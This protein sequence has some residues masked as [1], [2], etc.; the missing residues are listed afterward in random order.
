MR[1]S[2]RAT[3]GSPAEK[4]DFEKVVVGVDPT[5][6]ASGD[7]CGI[8]VVGRRRRADGESEA[9]VLADRSARGLSP[10]GWARRARVAAEAWGAASIVAEV[11]Q[12]GEMVKAVFR[13][14]GCEVPVKEVRAAVG[15]RARAEPV[16]ALYERGRVKHA[17]VFTELEE[18]LAAIGDED[19]GGLS[20]DRADA[21][22]WAVTALLV[23][24]TA[25]PR[26]RFIP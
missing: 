18:E 15:K 10:E 24:E 12:G 2:S 23:R 9:V 16:A 19:G 8:V 6:S 22:V 13:A 26:A 17:G 25:P 11:N 21:L 5:A 14:V 20:L 4:S 3:R 1:G 7:A